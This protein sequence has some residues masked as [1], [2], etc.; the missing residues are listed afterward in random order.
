MFF[1]SLPGPPVFY[2]N[3][4]NGAAGG[5]RTY[6]LYTSIFHKSYQYLET[7]CIFAKSWVDMK[8]ELDEDL[9]DLIETG[10]SGRYRNVARNRVLY[11][12]LMRAYQTMESVSSV[13]ELKLYSFLHYEQLR[14]GYSG[15]SS[16][17]LDNRYVHRLLFEERDDHIT[18]KLIEIDDTHYGNKK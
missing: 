17:R 4:Q 12:G 5:P 6:R 15:L 18:L 10:E 13:E 3:V 9:K 1:A 8:I 14:H 7:F 16:V 2:L 11:A